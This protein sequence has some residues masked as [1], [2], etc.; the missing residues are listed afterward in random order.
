MGWTSIKNGKL[1]ALAAQ[2]FDVFITVD[3]NLSFQQ[4]TVAFDIAIIVLQAKTNRLSE[5]R[6]LL[7]GLEGA[8]TSAK[9]GT[10]TKVG[11]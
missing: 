3:R 7:P 2:E 11:P 9:A 8:L 10:V 6:T 5:L 4:N 1:L